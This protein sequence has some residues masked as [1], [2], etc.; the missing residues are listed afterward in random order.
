[1][2]PEE[3]LEG[4]VEILERDG[5][6]QGELYVGSDLP[7]DD[8]WRQTNS[9][10]AP[11]CAMGAIYRA[12]MGTSDSMFFQPHWEAGGANDLLSRVFRRMEKAIGDSRSIAA[13][14]DDRERSKEDV[15]LAMKEAAYAE[16]ER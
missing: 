1:M 8:Q 4:A 10:S 6:C 9:E 3:V 7:R 14:N 16:E 5:W 11:A 2:T 12:A 13:W 15:I